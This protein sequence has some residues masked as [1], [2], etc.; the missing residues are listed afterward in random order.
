MPSGERSVI[1]QIRIEGQLDERWLRWFDGLVV[2][3][4]PEGDTTISGVMDHAA[5]HGVLDRIRDLGLRLVSVQR[6]L[7]SQ[8]NDQERNDR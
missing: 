8:E 2:S 4:H 6:H 1:Y 7:I 3:Y 5:L